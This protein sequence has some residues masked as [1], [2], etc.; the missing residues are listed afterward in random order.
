MEF[1]QC[2][3]GKDGADVRLCRTGAERFVGVEAA[4]VQLLKRHVAESVIGVISRV[5]GQ[6]QRECGKPL[7][8]AK[9]SHLF[10]GCVNVNDLGLRLEVWSP[11]VL[12]WLLLRNHFDLACSSEIVFLVHL[13]LSN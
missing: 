5:S 12:S 7:K 2:P 10:E 9:T 3:I 8:P 4:K 11:L 6:E 1:Y 13:L